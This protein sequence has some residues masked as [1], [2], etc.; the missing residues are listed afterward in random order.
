MMAYLVFGSCAHLALAA[1]EEK[2]EIPSFL[3]S[4]AHFSAPIVI[5]LTLA[6]PVAIASP[7]RLPARHTSIIH[8]ISIHTGALPSHLQPGGYCWPTRSSLLWFVH[9]GH[10]HDRMVAP[11]HLSKDDDPD[12]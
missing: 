2:Q 10:D 6:H 8:H 11:S 3:P 7:S 4:F 1:G 12:L 9:R 5:R